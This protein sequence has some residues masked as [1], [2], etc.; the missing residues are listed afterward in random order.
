MTDELVRRNYSPG[1]ARAYLRNV[2]EFAKHFNRPLDQLGLEHVREY[3]AYLFETRQLSSSS[4]SQQVAALRF[5]YVKTCRQPGAWRTRH[6]P[7]ERSRCL[8]C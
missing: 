8:W 5:F 2:S 3:S 7:K 6:I 1:T 4:V